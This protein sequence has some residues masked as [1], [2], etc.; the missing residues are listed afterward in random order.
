MQRN[1]DQHPKFKIVGTVKILKY[2]IFF[3]KRYTLNWSEE[4]FVIKKVKNNDL[5]GKEI[6]GTFYEKEFQ[7]PNIMFNIF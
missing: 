6:L 3:A 7:K 4:V 2:Q 5:D 1:N